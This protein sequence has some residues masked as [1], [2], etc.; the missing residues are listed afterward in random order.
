MGDTQVQME[1][2]TVKHQKSEFIM[3]VGRH[4]A[5]VFLEGLVDYLNFHLLISTYR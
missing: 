4:E 2:N 1:I 5:K 3:R